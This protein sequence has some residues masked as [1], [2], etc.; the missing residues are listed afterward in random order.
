MSAPVEVV[1]DSVSAKGLQFLGFYRVK[2]DLPETAP[3]SRVAVRD[4]SRSDRQMSL[5][6][7]PLSQRWPLYDNLLYS[8]VSQ[9]GLERPGNVLAR[10]VVVAEVYNS[11]YLARSCR[12]IEPV[13]HFGEKRQGRITFASSERNVP[14]LADG[15]EHALQRLLLDKDLNIVV[16]VLP[17]VLR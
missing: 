8:E 12:I 13:G 2:L 5:L 17:A 7:L 9:V 10:R 14:T 16:L 4:F 11:R 15:F 6:D 1:R 3:S